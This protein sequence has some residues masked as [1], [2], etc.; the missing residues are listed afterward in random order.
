MMWKKKRGWTSI[1][2]YSNCTAKTESISSREEIKFKQQP[3]CYRN[4]TTAFARS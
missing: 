3:N 4:K 1:K 2:K